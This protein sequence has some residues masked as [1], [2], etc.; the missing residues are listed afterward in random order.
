MDHFVAKK[1]NFLLFFL[2]QKENWPKKERKK[3]R[4]ISE[5]LKM[6]WDIN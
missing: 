6:G 5:T 4:F 1:P 3:K 2:L